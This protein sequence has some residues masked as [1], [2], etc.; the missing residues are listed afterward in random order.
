MTASASLGGMVALVVVMLVAMAAASEFPRHAAHCDGWDIEYL[1]FVPEGSPH[2]LLPTVLLLHGAGDRAASFIQAWEPLARK[3]KIVLLAPQLPRLAAFEEASP[4]VFRCLV[5]DAR[6]QAPLDAHR[7]YIFGHSMGG[8]LA[9]DG[10]LLESNYFAAAA[11]H[12][13]GI[14]DQYAGIVR[15]AERKI[16][17]AIYIGSEDQLVS[18]PVVRKTRDLLRKAGFPIQYQEMDNHGHNYYEMSNQINDEVWRFLEGKR[19]P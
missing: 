5:E 12:A 11:I 10:A 8:Y 7:V 13:M 18:L 4:K 1:T 19:L 3:K 15:Q 9:Y 14:E 16:P 17:I 2:D 6:K